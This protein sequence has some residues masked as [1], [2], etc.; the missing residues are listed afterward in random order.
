MNKHQP[1]NANDVSAIFPVD[2]IR[3]MFPALQQ[4]GDFIFMDNAAGAQIPQS[5]LDAV[6]N[7]LMAHNVQRGGRYSRSVAVDQAIADARESVALLINAYSP[8]EICFGMNA[9]SFI[10][11]V[12]LGIGQMLGERD[13][14]V[15]TDMDHDAN[16]AT[17][18]A[19]AP[20]GAKFKW[21]RMRDDGN[22]HVDDLRP[23][24][25]DRTRLV[26]CTVTAHSIGSIVD[27]AAVADIAHAAGAEVFLD[28]VHYGPHG[29]I[30]VQ[31]W[32][33][34]Y[35]VCSGYKNFSPHMGFL[36]G[37][38]ET[39]KRLPTFR[40]DFIPDEPPYKVEAGTFIYENVSGMDAAVQYLELIGRNFLAENNRSRRDNLV[41]GMNAIRDYELVLAREMLGVLKECGAT[42]YGVADEARLNERV[43]TFCFNIGTLSPQM[44]VEAMAEMQIGIRDGHMYAPR[45]MKRLNLSMDSGAIRASLVHYNTVGEVRRFG[46]ALRAVIAKL[47]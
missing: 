28:C 18:L 19:L 37:R 29:L 26:A 12:S 30:D 2:T 22:L 11:L 15:I 34:D 35:L 3:A 44:I 47:S 7:H 9:T 33:C 14:I 45:L 8:A 25:S 5:V 21:W 6:T 20:A 42:I 32:D 46:E 38:F 4:A 24:I 1:H 31:A 17:W 43:P 23:L 39:L 40:E 10:R 41:A 13:E 16:I 36:W 27:V